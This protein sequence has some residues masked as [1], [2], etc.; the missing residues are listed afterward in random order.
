MHVRLSQVSGQLHE[1]AGVRVGMPVTV[2]VHVVD[3]ISIQQASI[4][5]YYV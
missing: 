5:V 3:W 1:F 2:P 4:A